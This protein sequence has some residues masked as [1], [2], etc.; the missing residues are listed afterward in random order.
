MN[1]PP[2]IRSPRTVYIV[3][4]AVNRKFL[5]CRTYTGMHSDVWGR[6][7]DAHVFTN[8][9]IAQSCASNINARTDKNIAARVV[10]VTIGR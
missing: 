1:Q 4:D 9:R 6:G 2:R 5:N 8:R 10:P 3:R 7:E